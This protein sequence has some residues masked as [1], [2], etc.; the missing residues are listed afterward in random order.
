MRSQ[1]GL[2]L[3]L[4]F[5]ATDLHGDERRYRT[6]FEAVLAE[7]PAA[8]F[9]GGDLLPHAL[10][11]RYRQGADGDDF[12]ERVLGAGATDLRD[13]LGG[14][15]PQVFLLLG[16]DDPRAE[17]PALVEGATRGLWHYVH[18]Q[19]VDWAGFVVYGYACVPPTPFL[20][21]D[22][23]RYDVSRY[24]DPG[25]IS[26]EEGWRTAPVD[27]DDVRLG[28]IRSDLA[29]LARED[30]E[31]AIWLFHSPPH[32]TPL[33][34]A[35]LDGR[36]VDHAPVDV[37]VG[38][39][40]IRQFIETRQPRLTLHG[41]IHEAARLTGTWRMQIGRTHVIQGAHDGPELALVR[42][43][44]RDPAA[45]TRTLHDVG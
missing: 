19:R 22:W 31:R 21:K 43:D 8:L 12:V 37:H 15:A 14:D 34:R 25:C 39:V 3:M 38:S 27:A 32:G 5:F 11:R 20:L 17:E 7:R 9:L 42:F 10:A 33:D 24:L 35:A 2:A 1:G 13:R 18:Q 23:E 4:A 26:P 29:G 28:T 41:H 44:P 16:N 30:Q 45:A 6:L 36:M 40:A